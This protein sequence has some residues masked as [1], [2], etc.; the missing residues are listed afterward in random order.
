MG[1]R[2]IGIGVGHDAPPTMV[3]DGCIMIARDLISD[4]LREA[5]LRLRR[6]IHRHPELSH[7]EFETARSV[8]EALAEAGI[9]R[10]S[11]IPGTAGFFADIEG[12]RPGRMLA[13]RADL[14][15]LPIAEQTGLEYASVNAGVMHACG[16]DAHTAMVYAAG[17]ALDDLRAR[18]AGRVRLIFQ[19]AEEKEPLGARAAI[20]A[21]ALEGVDAIIGLH[22]DPDLPAGTVGGL[23]PGPRSAASDEFA[24]TVRGV[25]AHGA[26][27]DRGVDAV[28]AAAAVVQA[29]QGVVSRDSPPLAPV[30]VTVGRIHGG[31]AGNVIADEVRLEGIL[32]TQDPEVRQKV[33]TCVERSARAAAAAHGAE[34]EIEVVEGEPPILNDP[35]VTQLVY[36]AAQA[37]V[38][39]PRIAEGPPPSMGADDFAFYLERAPGMMLRLGVGNEAKGAVHPLHHPRFTLD[40]AALEVGV[41]VLAEAALRYLRRDEKRAD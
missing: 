31:T 40:E 24:V 6:H 1:A 22:V 23:V 17:R 25:A 34:A 39:G 27:P 8:R 33:R 5:M 30:V 20:A 41:A 37:V 11:P 4:S 28:L 2:V 38:G 19:P 9:S 15:A 35:A 7:A 13:L 26:R 3:T 32:R 16:H 36:E 14:D 29:L 12:D 10:F 18:L 21:G